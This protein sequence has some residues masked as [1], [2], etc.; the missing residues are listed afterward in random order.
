MSESKPS[1]LKAR[2]CP[3]AAA[4]PWPSTA[5]TWAPTRSVSTR[6][7]SAGVSGASRC[8]RGAAAESRAAARARRAGRGARSFSSVWTSP[9][10]AWA[11][12]WA[13]SRCIG[14]SSACSRPGRTAASNSVSPSLCASGAT[15]A[16]AM[17][18]I[19]V[20]SR[21]SAMPPPCSHRPQARAVAG[22]P[23]ARRWWARA[24]WKVLAAA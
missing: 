4:S 10:S 22:S 23:A 17:R 1:S 19:P 8:R 20:P 16:R 12:S 21:L 13:A 24:S 7:R 2:S 15:P 6:S 9:R 3:T 11:C 14:T 5:A 18:A